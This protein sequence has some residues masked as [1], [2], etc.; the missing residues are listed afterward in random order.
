MSHLHL[1][2]SPS[3]A[4]PNI[5][6]YLIHRPFCYKTVKQDR[7]KKTQKIDRRPRSSIHSMSG[8]SALSCITSVGT[9]PCVAPHYSCQVITVP[10]LHS[11]EP[12]LMASSFQGFWINYFTRVYKNGTVWLSLV[13][14]QEVFYKKERY[15]IFKASVCL[16]HVLLMVVFEVALVSE[17]ANSNR[18]IIKHVRSKSKCVSFSC[19][20][21]KWVLVKVT[22]KRV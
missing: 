5:C 10:S 15:L 3:F 20:V 18:L 21:L 11:R 9:W 17:M 19:F 22:A 6:S 13:Y 16:P 7:A 12:H 1:R 8:A 2:T 4:Q 14:W